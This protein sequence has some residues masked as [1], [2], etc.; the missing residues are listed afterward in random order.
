MLHHASIGFERHRQGCPEYA[1]GEIKRIFGG[2]TEMFDC[3][4]HIDLFGVFRN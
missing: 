4:N 2:I 1:M 3:K